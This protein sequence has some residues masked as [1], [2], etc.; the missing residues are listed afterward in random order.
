MSQ[1]P[2]CYYRSQSTDRDFDV[3]S[4]SDFDIYSNC[5]M[6]QNS[7]TDGMLVGRCGSFMSDSSDYVGQYQNYRLID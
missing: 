2:R 4:E 7:T 5:G 3:H 6:S 1:I